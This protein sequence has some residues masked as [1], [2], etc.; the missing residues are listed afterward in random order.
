MTRVIPKTICLI[1]ILVLGIAGVVSSALAQADTLTIDGSGAVLGSMQAQYTARFNGDLVD[2]AWSSS[3]HAKIDKTTGLLTAKKVTKD[4]NAVVKASYKING[5]TYKASKTVAITVSTLAIQGANS[6]QGGTQSQYTATFNGTPIADGWSVGPHKYATIDAA[7]GLLSANLVTKNRNVTVK[8]TYKINGSTYKTKLAVTIGATGVAAGGQ[9]ITSTSANRSTLPAAAVPQQPLTNVA[10]FSIFSAN[11][12]GMHCGD[13]DHR[14]ASI[15]PPF[16]VLH[17]QVV[18]KGTASSNPR[19]L[20]SADVD[21][22][23]SAASNPNDP[24]LQ[25]PSGAP[26]FKTNFWD[27]NSLPTGHSLAFDAYNPFYPPNILSAFPLPVDTGLPTPDLAQLYPTTG[28]GTLVATQ[29][30][31]PGI[32]NPYAVNVPQ[33]FTRFDVDY[34]YF[35]SFPAFGYRQSGINWFAADGIPTV[36]VD[37][38]G[39]SN[40]FPLM[41][42]QA[43]TK[44]T[45]LTGKSGQVIASTDTV[46]PVSGETNC[47]KCHT[48]TADGGGGYA[49]AIPGIDPG[50]TIQGSP[51][52]NT[53]FTVALA[54]SDDPANPVVVRR[55]WAADINIL[56]LHDAK[57]STSLASATPVSCQVCHYTPA[58]DLAHVGPLGPP[59]PNANGRDQKVHQSNSRVIH[60]FH[61]QFTDLFPNDMVPPN[62]PLRHDNT[63]QVVINAYVLN[64]LYQTC[65]QCHP[66]ADTKCLRG[67]MF[68]GGLVCND[69]H[70]SMA[71]VGNDYS[72]NFSTATPGSQDLTRRIPWV[73]EPKCQSCHTGDAMSN[74]TG[75]A[76]VIKSPD[77]I[78]LLQA[79]LTNNAN[80]TPIEATNKRFAEETAANGATVLYRFSKGHSGLACQSCHGSTHAEWPVQPETGTYIS[81]DNMAAKQLQGHAGKITECSACHTRS[82][83]VTLGGPH[84]MHPVGD[85]N[86]I[87]NHDSLVGSQRA[88]CQACHGA[89]GQGTVLSTVSTNRTVGSRPFTKGEQITCG[90][91][92]SNP[93]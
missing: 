23:Y 46:T 78:R 54:S 31:M 8:V 15:L 80:A 60:T 68:N 76:N 5:V 18:R 65:Y 66:G 16:N 34:P 20:T 25:N 26:I 38:F 67:A 37:D 6:V 42:V 53:A 93:L 70:G 9:S 1:L 36:P 3:G 63:G 24:A 49:A 89:T 82:P 39:R 57:H 72:I 22:L 91:C 13:L 2:V 41:R 74:M 43:R 92:H 73:N 59:D 40:P 11:D 30:E 83:G 86:F 10:G 88:E 64:K 79:Y 90:R 84:G 52:S 27:P 69:C 17:A 62:N 71:Q 61:A 50:A 56:R 21:V 87:S 48:S 19:I 14:I 51:R 35:V 7:T 28:T 44:S 85:S 58:L 75:S 29:Q 45:A 33:L 77:G 81:N 4:T 32:T 12:L 55:E 47:Y